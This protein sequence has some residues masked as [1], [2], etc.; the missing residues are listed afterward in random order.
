MIIE[1]DYPT[2]VPFV[3]PG[4][5][6]FYPTMEEKT[7]TADPE[8]MKDWLDLKHL[9]TFIFLLDC[10]EECNAKTCITFLFV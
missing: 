9:S 2:N 3:K 10:V 4:D 7:F 5:R 8:N 1:D 6:T